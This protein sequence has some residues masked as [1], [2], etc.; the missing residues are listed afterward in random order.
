MFPHFLIKLK[1]GKIRM[2]QRKSSLSPFTNF[3]VNGQNVQRIKV[4]IFFSL[5]F[6]TLLT[7]QTVYV[8]EGL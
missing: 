3:T 4:F 1:L 2:I 7:L 5:E 8:K 6:E